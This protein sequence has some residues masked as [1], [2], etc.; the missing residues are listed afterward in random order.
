M[1]RRRAAAASTTRGR[2]PRARR[3]AGLMASPCPSRPRAF[4]R[5]RA[6]GHRFGSFAP[7]NPFWIVGGAAALW[8]VVLTFGIG[9]RR[10]DFPRSD[11]EARTVMLISA[12]LV[13]AAIGTAVYSGAA[14]LGESKG[15][16]HG[17]EP[18]G[19]HQE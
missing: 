6:I 11:R 19:K 5:S 12:V 14:G 15:V 7:V 16:R 10:E 2:A 18:A 3:A 9:L 1:R 17:P 4:A 13:V 8:A